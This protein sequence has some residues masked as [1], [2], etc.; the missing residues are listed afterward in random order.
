MQP[1]PG[2]A[3]MELDALEDGLSYKYGAPAGAAAFNAGFST[4]PMKI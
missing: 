4:E 3:P 1:P 2:A